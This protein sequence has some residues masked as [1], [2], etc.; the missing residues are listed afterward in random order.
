MVT[1][2]EFFK[3]TLKKDVCIPGIGEDLVRALVDALEIRPH[4][5]EFK[6]NLEK[7]FLSDHDS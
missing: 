7:F 2:E 1:E 4:D 5:P 6:G 3:I